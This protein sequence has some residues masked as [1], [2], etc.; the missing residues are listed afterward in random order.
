MCYLKEIDC[1]SFIEMKL[2]RWVAEHACNLITGGGGS[3]CIP[4][5]S[6]ARAIER[7]ALLHP[8]ALPHLPET[9]IGWVCESVVECLSS[10]HK[11]LSSISRNRATTTQVWWESFFKLGVD[12][13][14]CTLIFLYQSGGFQVNSLIIIICVPA[15]KP[16][17]LATGNYP[18]GSPPASDCLKPRLLSK[19]GILPK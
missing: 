12:W 15:L 3:E 17:S 11:I 16:S 5:S 19:R 6:A 14:K 1:L 9:W 18:D 8:H 10:I 4:R 2:E 7:L 13:M